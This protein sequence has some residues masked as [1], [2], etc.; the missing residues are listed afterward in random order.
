MA[1]TKYE[2]RYEYFEMHGL[3]FILFAVKFG[4]KQY[5]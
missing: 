2:T 5:L 1:M 3:K 4:G